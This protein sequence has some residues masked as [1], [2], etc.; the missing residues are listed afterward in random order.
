[1]KKTFILLGIMT[2]LSSCYSVTKTVERSYPNSKQINWPDS[3]APEESK[4]F[5]HNEIFINA[6]PETVWDVLIKAKEWEDYYEGASDLV[7]IDNSTG[8]LNQNSIFTWKTMGL[9]F[10]STIEEFEAPYCLSWA[11]VNKSIQ[12]YHA[13][14]IIPTENGSRL[15]TS[16]AQ[17]GFMTLPQ[18]LFVPNK[19]G[20]LHDT[21][22]E[23]IKRK[24][25]NLENETITKND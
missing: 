22:L 16:E 1:M 9:D 21:W 19:L 14:L 18:K 2:V 25:E 23:E 3:Y 24:S 7:L 11:S 4:F 15:I 6:P 5:V 17:H 12:G 13:W 20:R 8:R 10:T